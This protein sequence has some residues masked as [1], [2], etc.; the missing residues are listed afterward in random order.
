MADYCCN[1]RYPTIC[2]IIGVDATDT[3]T[4]VD[5]QPKAID[6]VNVWPLLLAR[7]TENPREYL[8]TTEASI[9]FQARWKLLVDAPMMGW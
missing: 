6:G 5:G 2:T 8:P 4:G 1:S 9:I 3:I 7:A